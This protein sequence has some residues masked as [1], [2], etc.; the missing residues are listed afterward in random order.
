MYVSLFYAVKY[1][2]ILVT[3]TTLVMRFPRDTQC[4]TLKLLKYI[5]QLLMSRYLLP[6]LR[7][8]KNAFITDYYNRDECFFFEI[9][10]KNQQNLAPFLFKSVFYAGYQEF[11]AWLHFD[12]R[13][14]TFTIY[15]QLI[16]F[17]FHHQGGLL[18]HIEEILR[19]LLVAIDKSSTEEYELS[20]QVSEEEWEAI[21]PSKV[22]R[23]NSLLMFLRVSKDWIFSIF[24]V[25]WRFKSKSWE[26]N[27]EILAILTF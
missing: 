24:S 15:K 2:T 23:R 26:T 1:V 7:Y 8:F 18:C 16:C 3:C 21:K 14:P 12:L 9:I 11:F 4:T 25:I 22:E 19:V 5:V 13:L 17:N 10:L 27:A 6:N 20:N